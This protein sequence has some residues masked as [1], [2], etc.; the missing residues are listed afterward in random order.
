MKKQKKI[1]LE[2]LAATKMFIY[3]NPFSL[4]IDL[5]FSLSLSASSVKGDLALPPLNPNNSIANFNPGTPYLAVTCK[6]NKARLSTLKQGRNHFFLKGTKK[7]E[8]YR[9]VWS[10]KP[11]LKFLGIFH[12]SF[13][14]YL[15][16]FTNFISEN[17]S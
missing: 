4:K 8:Y 7:N 9:G 3:K 6:N 1:W 5:I 13:G 14:K 10:D 16:E 11:M 2:S 12:A 17:I 15:M